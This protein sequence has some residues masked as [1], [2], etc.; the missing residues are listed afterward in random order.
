MNGA[1]RKGQGEP[2]IGSRRE[3]N[4]GGR[5]RGYRSIHTTLRIV[6]ITSSVVVVAPPSVHLLG[7]GTSGTFVAAATFKNLNSRQICYPSFNYNIFTEFKPYHFKMKRMRF[8][9]LPGKNSKNRC[10][11]LKIAFVSELLYVNV[12]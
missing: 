6:A 11:R 8:Q 2:G 4:P 5:G 12:D 10:T 9:I 3:G 1:P 7:K